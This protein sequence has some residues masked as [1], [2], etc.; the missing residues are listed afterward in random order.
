MELVEEGVDDGDGVAEDEG[1]VGSVEEA[2]ER[3]EEGRFGGE[4]VDVV[5]GGVDGESV[6]D[7]AETVARLRDET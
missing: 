2:L 1:R 5:H 7:E 3:L 4:V 6:V